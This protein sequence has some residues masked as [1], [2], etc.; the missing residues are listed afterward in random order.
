MA[1]GSVL[2]LTCGFWLVDVTGHGFDE[3]W[4]TGSFGLFLTGVV[5]GAVGGRRPKQ[6]RLLAERLA[7]EDNEPSL[8]LQ[9]LLDDRLSAALN[10]AAT[11]AMLGVLLLMVW[12]PG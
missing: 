10:A 9:R 2:V 11:I 3:G 12:R 6:A 4:L 7:R 8:E 1:L 5:L